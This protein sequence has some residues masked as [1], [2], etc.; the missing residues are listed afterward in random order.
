MYWGATVAFDASLVARVMNTPPE[1]A[2]PPKVTC[3]GTDWPGATVK[4]AGSKICAA[5]TALDDRST[6]NKSAR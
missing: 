3:K 4:L 5:K 2:P 6:K 1:G